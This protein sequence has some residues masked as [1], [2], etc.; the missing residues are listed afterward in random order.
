MSSFALFYSHQSYSYPGSSGPKLETELQ[1]LHQAA[2]TAT[3]YVRARDGHRE[4]R[5]LD[6]P[7]RVRV[8]VEF[9]IHRGAAVALAV[10]QVRT[11]FELR[12][13]VGFSEGKAAADHDEL[14]EGFDDAANAVVA[15]VPTMEVIREAL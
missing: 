12:H 3:G 11:G 10:A 5:L 14:I 4:E 9:G 2:D 1:G 6:I 8:T 13:L 15:K 7:N